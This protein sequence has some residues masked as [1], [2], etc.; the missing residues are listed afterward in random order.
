MQ[1][2]DTSSLLARDL[3]RGGERRI[4]LLVA[5]ID[6]VRLQ[7][8][9]EDAPVLLLGQAPSSLRRHVLNREG[10]DVGHGL[11]LRLA[12]LG[13]RRRIERQR[14]GLQADDRRRVLAAL[15]RVSVTLRTVRSVE[16]LPQ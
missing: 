12:V 7:I 13:G 2:S 4:E 3:K 10:R 8:E 6:P 5:E 15:T 16:R 14:P 11:E 9:R 1:A